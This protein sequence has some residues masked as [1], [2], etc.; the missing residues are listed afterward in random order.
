[1]ESGLRSFLI[2]DWMRGRGRACAKLVETPCSVLRVPSGRRNATYKSEY[3]RS[4]GLHEESRRND[5]SYVAHSS[6]QTNMELGGLAE[7]SPSA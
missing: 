1:M 4:H 6:W 2:S 3:T 5:G 7:P